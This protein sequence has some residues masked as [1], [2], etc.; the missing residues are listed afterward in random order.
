VLVHSHH[1][2]AQIS[3]RLT[4][5]K[6]KANASIQ[7]DGATSI[8]RRQRSIFTGS[9]SHTVCVKEQQQNIEIAGAAP[10]KIQDI[11]VVWL[12]LLPLKTIRSIYDQL[13][14]HKSKDPEELM[15]LQSGMS[16]EEWEAFKERQLKKQEEFRVSSKAKQFRRWMKKR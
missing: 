9:I 5:P 6:S 13:R 10:P 4:T 12:L 2:S 7:D 15:R 1:A 11:F 3:V 8:K 16:E 14:G